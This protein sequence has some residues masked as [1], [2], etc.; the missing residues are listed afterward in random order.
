MTNNRL[1]VGDIVSDSRCSSRV[2][3]YRRGM[4]G[5]RLLALITEMSSG[6]VSH[7]SDLAL[8]GDKVDGRVLR[9]NDEEWTYAAS[10]G[11]C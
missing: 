6:V 9:W 10:L 2:G 1:T 3:R 7:P 4:N 11:N 5:D 8:I